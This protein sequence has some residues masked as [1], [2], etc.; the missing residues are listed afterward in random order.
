M[1][2]FQFN[3]R[4]KQGVGWLML[5]ILLMIGINLYVARFWKSPP[6]N[7]SIIN[8]EIAV[9]KV[10][11]LSS[12]NPNT[13]SYDSLLSFGLPRKLASQLINYRTK[14]GLFSSKQELKKLYAMTDSL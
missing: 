4:E 14:V 2:L 11:N 9:G 12:F 13:V 6:I 8:A 1:Q 3:N 5:I 7:Y 10:L